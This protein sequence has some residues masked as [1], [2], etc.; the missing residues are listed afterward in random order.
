MMFLA[1]GDCVIDCRET[2]A[3]SLLI[4]PDVGQIDEHAKTVYGIASENIGV[5]GTQDCRLAVLVASLHNLAGCL[6]KKAM[7]QPPWNSDRRR[8]VELAN[9]KRVN[10]IDRRDLV[11]VL[12]SISI[13]D[14]SDQHNLFDGLAH[15]CHEVSCVVVVVGNPEGD[16]H[17]ARPANI[18]RV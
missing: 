16:G 10:S 3:Q 5:S 13:L 18:S 4:D 9:P 8:L 15:L 17:G 1:M 2:I 14:L 6:T 12:D 11:G 7:V